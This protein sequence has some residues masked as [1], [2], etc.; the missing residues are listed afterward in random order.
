MVT[1]LQD[2]AVRRAVDEVRARADPAAALVHAGDED[3]AA[4]ADAG[5]DLHV[6]DETAG[7]TCTGALQVVPPSFEK[8]E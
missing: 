4:T 1:G 3:R 6:A 5:C 8:I 2:A 7:L